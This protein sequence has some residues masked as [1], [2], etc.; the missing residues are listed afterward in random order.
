MTS[1]ESM[2]QL[3]YRTVIHLCLQLRLGKHWHKSDMHL[4]VPQIISLLSF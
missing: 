2:Q 3:T 4:I 1:L